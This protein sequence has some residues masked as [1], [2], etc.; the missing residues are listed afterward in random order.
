MNRISRAGI[1]L[2]C[3]LGCFSIC[4]GQQVDPRGG[5]NLD[6][7]GG[8]GNSRQDTVPTGIMPLDTSVPA[9]YV[10]ISDERRFY[11]ET[12]SFS[13][14]D[15]R[16]DPL[17]FGFAH[18]GNLGSAAR[19][20]I[21]VTD[22]PI[23]FSTGL[24]QYDQYFVLPDSFRYYTQVVPVAKIKYSQ[25]NRSDRSDRAYNQYINLK[26]GRTF[27]RGFS[28]SIDYSRISQGGQF[29][30]QLQKDTGLGFG[31]W[32]HAPSGKYDAF[33]NLISN[34][35]IAEENGGVSNADS[36]GKRNF[37]DITFPTFLQGGITTHKHRIFLTKQIV[38]VL[39]DSSSIGMDIWLKAKYESGLYKYVDAQ[40]SSFTSYYEPPIQV[41]DRG[42]RQFTFV[43]EHEESMGIA[44]PWAAAH[45]TV[46]ASLRYRGIQ[47]EQEP[48]ERKINELYADAS[49]VF[50]W[51]EPLMLRGD[52]S[53][54]LGKAS[55][56]YSFQ[57]KGDLDA[58]LLGH[59]KGSWLLQNRQPYL[60]E[61]RWFV[62]QLP[63]YQE[64]FDHV[65]KTDIGVSWEIEK[66]DFE[67]GISWKV[68]DGFIYFDT[69]AL[70]RQITES[71]SIKQ[72]F[73]SKGVDLKWVGLNGTL[74][75][76][77][78]ARREMAIPERMVNA[79]LYGRFKVFDRK[80][81]VMPVFDFTYYSEYDGISYFPV[82]GVY[83][84]TGNESIPDYVRFDAGIGINVNFIKAYVRM[85]DFPGFVL[86]RALYQAD[87]YPHFHGYF[88]IGV[89]AGFFN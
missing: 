18:L 8:I 27:A 19:S 39:P 29:A 48:I 47:L 53:V 17:G 78:D 14:K 43:K 52:L 12:D 77:P 60:V 42:I 5:A 69:L 9:R 88:R 62:N 44:L 40:A 63:V 26:F 34:T 15:I 37:P 85:E 46:E 82:N 45:S 3:L 86:D 71:F 64:D 13:Y 59:F 80:L 36:I 84:L 75:L 67:A 28:L 33:Y 49:A 31:I 32:H 57:A 10:L 1:G 4:V 72:F 22:E 30:H 79:S 41:E 70:P 51:V 56:S 73:V 21:P 54:G 38:H 87:F 35:V 20:L 55:G 81:T 66:L 7:R 2:I 58:G 83:H 16:Q 50:H 89:E 65:F 24:S 68:W 23:G 74:V 61:S 11:N 76:Q 25:A 6:P